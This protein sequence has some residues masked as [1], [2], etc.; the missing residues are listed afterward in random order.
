MGNTGIKRML[1]GVC[2][3]LLLVSNAS[4]GLI[5]TLD[6]SDPNT[7]GTYRP[8][9]PAGVTE[10]LAYVNQLLGML[11]NTTTTIG[12]YTY[13]TGVTDYSGTVTTLSIKNNSPVVQNGQVSIPGGYKYVLAKYDGP[14]GGGIVWY[15]GGDSAT[16]P[17]NSGGFFL[18][19]KGKA[20]D[21]G[22]SHYSLFTV[23]P[24]PTTYL[25]GA[26]LLLPFAAASLR[27]LKK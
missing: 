9:E 6:Y 2:F 27:R 4:A 24:E 12:D 11:A 15:L 17:S 10:E 8:P 21:Y 14:N 22:L 25:A 13:K 16:I 26:L 20:G 18:S 23:V 3:L 1:A 7:V 19:D 5:L